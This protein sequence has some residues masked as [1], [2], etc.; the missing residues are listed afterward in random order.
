MKR[1]ITL[2]IVVVIIAMFLEFLFLGVKEASVSSPYLW[3]SDAFSALSFSNY[4][5]DSY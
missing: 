3:G 5:T 2:V 4:E 1:K